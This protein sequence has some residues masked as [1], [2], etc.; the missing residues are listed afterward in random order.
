M[1]PFPFLGLVMKACLFY[2]LFFFFSFAHA[3]TL[4]VST[5]ASMIDV[6]KEMGKEFESRNPSIK[7]AYNHGASG[8]LRGQIE[9]GAPVDLFFSAKESH[10]LD[11][12]AKGIADK[13]HYEIVAYNRLVLVVP[14]S[15]SSSSEDS[16]KR[17]AE[18]KSKYKM[19]IGTP[20]IVPAGD[21][22]QEV[23][24]SLSLQDRVKDH[25]VYGTSVRQVLDYVRRAEVDYAFV[26]FTDALKAKKDVVVIETFAENLHSP[27]IYAAASIKNSKQISL[28]NSFLR[29]VKS[30]AGKSIFTK[31]GFFVK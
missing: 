23:L 6:I 4:T 9:S 15:L 25:L 30:E 13:D 17:V 18:L 26:Y 7:I 5:A 28:A 16:L 19:A 8:A 3:E 20:K 12:V 21:Y 2:F 31:Y 29:F 22:A 24:L 27:I 10:V 11:L 1:A 14:A